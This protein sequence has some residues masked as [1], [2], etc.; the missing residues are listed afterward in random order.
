MKILYCITRSTWGGAQAHVFGLI[1]DQ[2]ARGNEVTLVVGEQGELS[3]RVKEKIN[4]VDIIELRSLKRAV[5]PMM[6]IVCIFELRKILKRQQPDIVHLHSSKAGTVG[7]LASWGLASKIVYT[8]HGWAFTEGVGEIRRI[9]FSTIEKRLAPLTDKILLVSK[10]DMN[11]GIKYGVIKKID[12][13][14]VIYNG[15]ALR[16]NIEH[17]YTGE[18]TT[19]NVVM[20]ARFA[21]PKQQKLLIKALSLTSNVN[22][23]LV[24]DGPQ[25]QDAV[26]YSEELNISKRI[27]FVGFKKDVF[28]YLVSADVF[29]LI[30][31]HEGLPISII[32]AMQAGLPIIASN[33][34]GIGE[35]VDDKNGLLVSNNVNDIKDAINLMKNKSTRKSMGLNS[36][37][38]FRLLFELQKEVDSVNN[39]Y[40]ELWL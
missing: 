30:S 15:V 36:V 26:R 13:V 5:N 35:L 17:Y 4:G 6:D 7:R 24:G 2:R 3:K 40:K 27:E 32:E 16:D 33:V 19:F 21:D 12:S 34:G 23:T 20:T 29:A 39:V 25:M 18:G 31:L 37:R 11:L 38:R 1:E 14:Q 28:P 22:L 10:Y 9:I 8:V